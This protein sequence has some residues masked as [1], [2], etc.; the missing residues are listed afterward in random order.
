[1][2]FEAWPI[3]NRRDLFSPACLTCIFRSAELFLTISNRRDG[4]NIVWDF[5][6]VFER[7]NIW[8]F[9]SLSC[10]CFVAGERLGVE[11]A[12]ALTM[13]LAVIDDIAQVRMMTT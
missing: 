10:R 13:N 11:E 9:L 12:I 1:M 5:H 3:S 6:T 8:R 4:K 7:Q 2:H